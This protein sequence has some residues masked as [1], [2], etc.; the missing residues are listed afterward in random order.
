MRRRTGWALLVAANVLCYCVL[1]F[2]QTSDAASRAA[3]RQ[4][5]ANAIEQR[6]EMIRLLRE[7]NDQLKQQ[8][9]LLRS[10]KLKVVLGEPEKEPGKLPGKR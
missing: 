9:A 1:S 7:I 5:F 3:P 10:G 4:P 8:N 6:M 2:Y